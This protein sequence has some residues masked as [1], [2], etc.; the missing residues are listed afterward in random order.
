M[1]LESCYRLFLCGIRG[2]RKSWRTIIEVNGHNV[3]HAMKRAG[4]RPSNVVSWYRRDVC[5]I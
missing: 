1:N 5:L 4:V 2:D 3:R